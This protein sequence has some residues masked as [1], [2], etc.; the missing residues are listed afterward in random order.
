MGV[1]DFKDDTLASIGELITD[2]NLKS[3]LS[4]DQYKINSIIID[5]ARILGKVLPSG[6]ANW[7]IA[8]ADSTA[9]A[10]PTPTSEP[11]KF[12]MKLNEFK[13]KN[14]YIVYD[15]QQGKMYGK[16]DDFNYL[17]NGNQKYH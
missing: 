4:G 2:I 11:S 13:I 3:V 6:K 15:D 7:D 14:A 16:L 10:A 5:K 17:L 1:D 9:A 8:K 12:A